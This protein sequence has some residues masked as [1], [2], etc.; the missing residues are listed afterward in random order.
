MESEKKD[1]IKVISLS[2]IF[3]V[4]VAVST[5]IISIPVPA[6]HGYIN[7]GDAMVLISGL[8][9]GPLVG[10]IAGG[11]GSSIA[12]LILS[13]GYAP[14]TLI[15]KGLEGI[16]AGTS[17]KSGWKMKSLMAAIA[18]TEMVA[19]YMIAEG[20]LYGFGAALVELPGNIFQAFW[21]WTVS[22]SVTFL[23]KEKYYR[24]KRQ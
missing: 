1:E 9:Y 10:F 16:I 3:V 24:A 13:P 8:L 6:T 14:I 4:L 12:D 18:V 11:F 7:L 17:Y 5:M 2:I 20:F 19:G 21:G 23:I 22:L 15:V